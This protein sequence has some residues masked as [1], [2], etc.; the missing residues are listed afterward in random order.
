MVAALKGAATLPHSHENEEVV[1]VLKGV[2]RFHVRG[3]DV[4]LHENEMLSI[5]PGV[6]HSAV[7][8]DDVVAVV[9]CAPSRPDWLTVENQALDY[10]E[11]QSLWAV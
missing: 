11:E 9:I 8:L 5:S 2:W 7:A 10:D 6:E 1:L 4:T 3:E